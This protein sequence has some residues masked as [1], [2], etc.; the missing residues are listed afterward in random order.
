MPQSIESFGDHSGECHRCHIHRVGVKLFLLKSNPSYEWSPPDGPVAPA[1]PSV[2]QYVVCKNCLTDEEIAR[3]LIP[4]TLFVVETL[5]LK[6]PRHEGIP[7]AAHVSA[8]LKIRSGNLDFA[9]RG[10][11]KALEALG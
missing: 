3:L 4:M 11:E 5:L 6:V 7:A 10:R 2:T 1:L 8:L 9:H